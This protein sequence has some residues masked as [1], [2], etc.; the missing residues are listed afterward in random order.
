[1][2]P[3]PD[4]EEERLASLRSHAILDTPP[5]PQ[6]D[7]IVRAA[8]LQLDTPVALLNLVDSERQWTKSAFGGQQGASIARETAF[9][10][11]TI[12]T[13]DALTVVPDA[14]LDDRFAANPLVLAPGGIRFYA[15]APILD[16]AGHAL[17]SLAVLDTRPRDFDAAA[18]EKLIFFG[19]VVASLLA[20]YRAN[21]ALRESEDHYRHT[22]ELNPQ[23]P[24]IA[25]PAGEIED[26]STRWGLLTGRHIDD[27]LGRGWMEVVHPDDLPPAIQKWVV[28]LPTGQPLDLEYRLLMA[29]S[30]Y[31]WFRVR[32]TARR[33]DNGDIM[34]WYGTVEDI[35][36]RKMAEL[37]LR[38]SQMR[39][40]QALDA[41]KL[42]PWEWDPGSG[43]VTAS[44]LTASHLGFAQGGELADF[45]TALARVHPEDRARCRLEIEQ[46]L[47]LRRDMDMDVRTVWPDGTT[48]WVRITGRVVE[49]TT[50]AAT[51]LRAVGLSFD[52]TERKRAEQLMVHLANHDPLT[53]LPNRRLLQSLLTQALASRADH[54]TLV[55]LCIDLDEFKTVNDAV[56]QE[57]GDRLLLQV[58]A[59]LRACAGTDDTLAH[60][61]GDAFALVS[62][63]Q[64]A[65]AGAEGLA[66]RVLCALAQPFD[67]G[68]GQIGLACSIGV[69]LA[70]DTADEPNRLQRNAETALARAKAGARGGYRLFEPAMDLLAQEREAMKLALRGALERNE[71]SLVYQPL[72]DL[73][74]GRV[75]GFEALM[76][77][78][79]AQ[80]GSIPPTTF[81]AI[82]E[83]SGLIARFGRWALAEACRKAAT[84]PDDIGV[85][86]NLSPA[87]FGYGDIR[88]DVADALAASGLAPHRLELEITET[89]LLRDT[90]ATMVILQALRGMG[91]RLALDDF[92]TGYASLAYLRR[93]TFDKIKID[94]SL[95][96]DLP[97][98]D[99]GDAILHAIIGLGR[100]LRIAITAEGV[101]TQEQQ[102]FLRAQDCGHAQGFFFARPMQPSEVR[103]FLQDQK[104]AAVH[105]VLKS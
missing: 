46:V 98:G 34:R 29:D 103:A 76:R 85:S 12:L 73:R 17:G 13:P 88:A 25:T 66:Q 83:E 102:D 80:W 10:A 26:A 55:L 7:R 6:L 59:R 41:G 96:N 22:V 101:E 24:W 28:C 8:A 105:G 71:L 4:D 81:I 95:V 56:G 38:D 74:S 94:R 78:R 62:K 61:G 60:Y 15:G 48:H 64:A 104:T 50:G 14:T 11:Y 42:G 40:H 27:A 93:F 49:E 68:D 87:Q 92:G 79:S 33:N 31:R 97:D 1:M 58:A 37:A 53:D 20:L 69:A 75:T 18:R 72:I 16:N 77:W 39:L 35:H 45:E 84:W 32:A 51:T 63:T 36:D 86:V 52:I 19:E 3:R 89:L 57:Q 90:D 44:T 54:E 82:A 9:C 65:R 21:A 30:T 70:P 5:D 23:I 67:A 99:S 91:V 2:V 43:R 47:A 100:S